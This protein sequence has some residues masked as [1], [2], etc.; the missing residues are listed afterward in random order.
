MDFNLKNDK[1][2]DLTVKNSSLYKLELIG[3]LL[4]F[5]GYTN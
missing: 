3:A 1:N 4:N 5:E 2:S